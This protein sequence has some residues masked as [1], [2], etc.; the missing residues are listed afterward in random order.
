MKNRGVAGQAAVLVG[1]SVVAFVGA[2][3]LRHFQH[4]RRRS[5]GSRRC[6]RPRRTSD[7]L[8]EDH[9][10]AQRTAAAVAVDRHG[11]ES[12][13]AGRVGSPSKQA[14]TRQLDAHARR[15]GRKVH[16]GSDAPGAPR[17]SRG[18]GNSWDRLQ[19]DQGRHGGEGASAT[20]RKP[21]STPPARSSKQFQR[22]Q[23][24]RLTAWMQTKIDNADQVYQR[25]DRQHSQKC[26]GSRSRH[27]ADD[28][29]RRRHRL[30]DDAEHRPA[31]RG[32]QG[33][34]DPHRQP[35]A[36]S[37][38]IDVHSQDE[39]GDLARDM[40]GMAAAIQAYMAQQ[41]AAEAEV[42]ELERRDWNNASRS[43]PR[44]WSEPS[45]NCWRAKEAAEGANR[46]KSEFLAN[47]SHEIR[48][49]MNGI[50]GMTE[51]ALDTP[52]TSEQREYLRNG[53]VV[54]RLPAGGHQRHP[55]L[56]QDRSGQARPR[57]D[58]LQSPRQSRRHR[59]ARLA[60]RAHTK[61]LELACH[62]LADVPD[63]LV[64]DP[65]RLRQILVNLVGNAIKF[66]ERGRGRRAA[67]TKRV[68]DRRRGRAALLTSRD[69]G[70]GIPA[71]KLGVAL[72]G[73]LAGR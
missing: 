12:E 20:A 31:D 59:A 38:T 35:R 29:S 32:A 49:P 25:G 47:M 68:A 11:A 15:V 60:L 1:I 2:G 56:L 4:H 17:P 13:V 14:L 54:G 41:Q 71:D 64:G 52:L 23:R 33:G 67:S 69:T 48:T 28:A 61:G 62:V 57:P 66:T 70:I 40:E 37:T 3:H 5:P 19:A 65:G 46:A 42:R 63:D 16:A 9:Q 30:R 8:A 18:C 44:N 36:R 7:R 27:R 21:S 58:R 34:S 73:V 10:S 50:I 51:L 53:Q 72:Q 22:G 45:P 55:R 26:F 6:T 43:A 39:L 24:R